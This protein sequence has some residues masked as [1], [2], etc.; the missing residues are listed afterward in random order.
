MPLHLRAPPARAYTVANETSGP[1][2]AGVG[3]LKVKFDHVIYALAALGGVFA[4]ATVVAPAHAGPP[5]TVLTATIVACDDV[6]PEPACD[7][8]PQAGDLVAGAD[9][10]VS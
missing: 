9:A 3:R 6:Q 1:V 8:V 7:L 10:R 2:A 4:I 5:E